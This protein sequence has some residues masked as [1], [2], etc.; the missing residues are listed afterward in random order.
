VVTETKATTRHEEVGLSPA[1]LGAV[2]EL[3]EGAASD[4]GW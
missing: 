2:R 4:G 1:Q 3:L